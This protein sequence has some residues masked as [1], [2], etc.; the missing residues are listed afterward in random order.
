M[1]EQIALKLITLTPDDRDY[2]R[3]MQILGEDTLRRQWWD[4]AESEVEPGVSYMMAVSRGRPLAWAGWLVEHSPA[5]QPVL[6]RCCNNYVRR[7]FRNRSPE[8]YQLVYRRRHVEVVTALGLPA[9]TF[10]FPEP[11]PLHLRDGWRRATGQGAAGTSRARP[12]ARLHR[13]QKLVW[14]PPAHRP[15]RTTVSPTLRL[16]AGTA[17]VKR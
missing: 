16:S 17:V 10:L 12:G 4:D 6:L 5:G 13:W 7:G 15:A 2:Q 8:L 9:V 14:S 3:Y 1:E 11:I